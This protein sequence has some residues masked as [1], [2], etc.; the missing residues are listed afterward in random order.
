MK[1]V[2]DA[3]CLWVMVIWKI[4]LSRGSIS[5]LRIVVPPLFPNRFENKLGSEPSKKQ[6]RLRVP[7]SYKNVFNILQPPP[8][9]ER[10]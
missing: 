7:K 8:N 3:V 4:K 9:K 2:T 5:G 6:S 10:R 1:N